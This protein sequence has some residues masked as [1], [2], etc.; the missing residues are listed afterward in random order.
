MISKAELDGRYSVYG[1]F[2]QLQIDEDITL[3][4]RN[5]LEIIAN[6]STLFTIE[7]SLKHQPELIAIMMNPGSSSPADCLY[8]ERRYTSSQLNKIVANEL[9]LAEPDYTQYQIMRLMLEHNIKH[10]R[11]LNLSDVREPN[12]QNFMK[13]LN[14][15]RYAGNTVHSIFS[16]QRKDE[17]LASIDEEVL[18]LLAWG[19]NLKLVG[20]GKQAFN[21]ISSRRY[22]GIRKDGN[23]YYH[24]LP[25]INSKQKEW[26]IEIG[27]QLKRRELP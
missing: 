3:S 6:D 20:L 17:L 11:I 23:L 12:S 5:R 19:V 8:K 7:D 25:R 2:Y 18:Y 27:K 9:T 21:C 1:S 26:L 13:Q 24:P 14:G 15:I 4:C 22:C 10:V 16:V